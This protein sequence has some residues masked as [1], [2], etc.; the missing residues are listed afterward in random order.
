[1]VKINP[2]QLRQPELPSVNAFVTDTFYKPDRQPTNPALKDLANSLSNLVPTLRRYDVAKEEVFKLDEQERA[3]A[4]FEANK[5]AF[6]ELTKNGVI[7]EGASPYYI[8]ALAKQQLKLDGREFKER[9]FDEWNKSNVWAND[10]PAAFEKFYRT[11]SDQF[12]TEKKLDS[13]A[14]STLVQGFLPDA[15]A[16]YNELSQRHREKRIAEI[17]KT[18]IDLLNKNVSAII[19]DF[20]S[21]DFLETEDQETQYLSN[22][23]QEQLDFM[24]DNH[25]NPRTANETIV[26]AVVSQAIRYKDPE[27][28]EI[29][30]K[31]KTNGNSKLSGTAYA[32]KAL[33]ETPLEIER[34]IQ[35]QANNDYNNYIRAK[36]LNDTVSMNEFGTYLKENQEIDVLTF[37]TN[38]NTRREENGIEPLDAEMVSDL[39][40]LAD[41]YVK[42]N[43]PIFI[44]DVEQ[45]KTLRRLIYTNPSNSELSKLLMNAVGEDGGITFETYKVLNEELIKAQTYS[46][47]PLRKNNVYLSIIGQVTTYK[48]TYGDEDDDYFTGLAN[49]RINQLTDQVIEQLSDQQFLNDNNLRTQTDQQNYLNKIMA[50]EVRRIFEEFNN[51]GVDVPGVVTGDVNQSQAANKILNPKYNPYEQ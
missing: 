39:N 11:F 45:I 42:A 38:E 31:I 23:V 35:L 32:D 51:A 9:L 18:N 8:N 5:N 24:I 14:P 27:Y 41:N 19:D 20:Q 40:A 33:K 17:E 36:N 26:D 30:N 50:D 15:D 43:A 34:L 21:V 25:M 10:D 16:A 12:K 28:L 29:L 46:D 22:M 4:D 47:S 13:Y 37:I 3:I 7:P 1:M 44:E 6:K 48:P 2:P 49:V